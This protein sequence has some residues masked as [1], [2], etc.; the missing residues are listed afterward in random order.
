[1]YTIDNLETCPVAATLQVMGGKW[2]LLTIYYLRFGPRRFNALRRDLRGIT[3]R[4][5]TM[6]LRTLEADGVV[7][8]KVFPTVPPQVEYRLTPRGE[9]LS[10]IIDAMEIWGM[11]QLPD[12]R[13]TGRVAAE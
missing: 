13:T 6:T 12:R 3:H 5:L 10:P 7:A 9:M 4:M 11:D 8:R 2:T 1:M